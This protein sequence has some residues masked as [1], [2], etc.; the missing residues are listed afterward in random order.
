[1]FLMYLLASE[2]WIEEPG[3]SSSLQQRTLWLKSTMLKWSSKVRSSRI[4]CM[5]STVCER[6]VE[7]INAFCRTTT[8]WQRFYKGGR[9]KNEPDG[10]RDQSAKTNLHP[11]KQPALT[12]FILT[13]HMDPLTSMTNTMFLGRG[14]RLEGAKNWIKWPSDTWKRRRGLEG[15]SPNCFLAAFNIKLIFIIITL[16]I[17]N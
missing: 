16:F 15:S 3:T 1:M 2:I 4:A 7:L 11:C 10:W 17:V 6:S 12:C 14:E 8:R 13:P 9:V 5:A